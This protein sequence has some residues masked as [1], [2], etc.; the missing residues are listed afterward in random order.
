MENVQTAATE[1]QIN[2]IKKL[3]ASFNDFENLTLK[4][5]SKMIG[6][7]L[8]AQKQGAAA[9]T[10][11]RTAAAPAQKINIVNGI[12]FY[13]N[14]IKYGDSKLQKMSYYINNRYEILINEDIDYHSS[15][16]DN[17]KA[18]IEALQVEIKNDTDIYTDYFEDDTYIIKP[19]NENYIMVLNAIA[20]L[21]KQL[22]EKKSYN[23][24][25]WDKIEQL[26]KKLSESCNHI[27]V[28]N[29]LIENDI[30]EEKRINQNINRRTIEEAKNEKMENRGRC[31]IESDTRY[32]LISAHKVRVF[33]FTSSFGKPI[34]EIN[35]I[36]YNKNYD[37]INYF[38]FE[39]TFKNIDNYFTE[40]EEKKIIKQLQR[41]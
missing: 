37:R 33:D 19:E 29:K 23:S 14:G 1:K 25:I 35:I 3:D 26:S 41:L 38:S 18:L 34:L 40:E 12:K 28:I 24:R 39:N 17:R 13:Y 6:R 5:A 10:E 36:I 4:E 16:T 21:C 27:E 22:K 32:I 20:S 9:G 30:Q 15:R 31:L 8:K 11:T 2:F 7:L